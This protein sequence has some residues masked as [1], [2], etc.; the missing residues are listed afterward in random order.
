[1]S[2]TLRVRWI[3]IANRFPRP[4]RSC[5]RCGTQR[6]FECS[7]KF[8]LNA[9]GRRLDAWLVYKCTTCDDTWNHT[10]FERRSTRDIDPDLLSGLE[11][12]DPALISRF[13]FDVAALRWVAHR[14][15]EFAGGVARREVL[16][17]RP[18]RPKRLEIFLRLPSP[19]SIRLD[20]LLSMELGLP[21]AR[22]A[23]IAKKDQLQTTTRLNRLAVNGTRV[24]I[25]LSQECGETILLNATRDPIVH[26]AR[27][28]ELAV[29]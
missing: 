17:E 6:A 4:W 14:V 11:A 18:D 23:T 26:C 10:L 28:S 1:M 27:E 7:G 13:A 29:D 24:G 16:G 20:R 3:L 15:E 9:N 25:E 12:N 21:R 5:S 2:C 8:R 22:I 19:V